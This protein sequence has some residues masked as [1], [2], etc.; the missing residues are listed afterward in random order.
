MIRP[1]SRGRPICVPSSRESLSRAFP[2]S[3]RIMGRSRM[4]R[5]DET[6]M[7]TSKTLRSTPPVPRMRRSTAL[8]SRMISET[9]LRMIFLI[10]S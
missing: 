8:S 9:R 10:T 4:L 5:K 7:R 3:S 2:M 1:A 6:R